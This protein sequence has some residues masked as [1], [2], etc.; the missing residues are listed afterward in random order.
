VPAFLKNNSD[1]T[2]RFY[3]MTCSWYMFWATNYP[4]IGLS[5]WGCNANMPEIITVAPHKVYKRDLIIIYDSTVT[6]SER[7][8]ISMSL[9]IVPK[10]DKW[11]GFFWLDEYIRFNKIWSNEIVI[12]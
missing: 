4:G 8:R 7:Y 12:Q 11:R 1:N 9:L 2:L 5:G 3:S 6:K 10:D